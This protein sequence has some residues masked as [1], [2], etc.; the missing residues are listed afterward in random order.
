MRSPRLIDK[1]FTEADHLVKFFFF[2]KQHALRHEH[3]AFI[4]ERA[5]SSLNL[6]FL[7]SPKYEMDN[8]CNFSCRH[9][10]CQ[11]VRTQLYKLHSLNWDCH[12]DIN[13][14]SMRC[15][16]LK[17][18]C[19]VPVKLPV[20]TQL[21]HHSC[22]G[23]GSRWNIDSGSTAAAVSTAPLPGAFDLL[24][25]ASVCVRTWRIR[26]VTLEVPL[27]QA[28]R[29]LSQHQQVRHQSRQTVTP[30]KLVARRIT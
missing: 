2:S 5:W 11:V 14:I 29:R 22:H 27:R 23:D 16:V 8:Q 12:T 25:L 17:K 1:I 4:S 19:T 6:L 18:T 15:Q 24:A 20:W 26:R 30:I 3:Q 13:D 9:F 10:Q 28:I 7:F 21:S